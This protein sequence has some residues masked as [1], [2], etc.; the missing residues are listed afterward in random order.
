MCI[1][2]RNI[3]MPFVAIN[4]DKATTQQ[5]R[6][7]IKAGLAKI[8]SSIVGK[9]EQYVMISFIKCDALYFG[10]KAGEAAYIEFKQLGNMSKQ[11]KN[12]LTAQIN[13]L[14]KTNL[15]IDGSKQYITFQSFT[16][17]SWGFDGQT[18]G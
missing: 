13:A 11:Q 7:T 15:G 18:F 9:P 10:G 14:I 16:A 8:L 3:K 6:D 2:D 17:D 5:Q 1:R 4:T 12:D